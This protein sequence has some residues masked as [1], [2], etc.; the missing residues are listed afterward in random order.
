MN[1]PRNKLTLLVLLFSVGINLF[2]VG[3]IFYRVTL[4]PEFGPRP[5]PRNVSWIV[6]DLTEIRQQEL[7]PLL[8]RN[9]QESESLRR[10]MFIA[11]RQVNDLMARSNFDSDELNSAFTALRNASADY[12]KI[13]HQQTVDILSRLT[14][15][16]RKLAQEFLQRRGPRGGPDRGNFQPR[17]PGFNSNGEPRNPPEQNQ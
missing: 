10:D 2:L 11:Q 16:E 7:M 14:E 1:A 3:G 15:A 13:S 9:R 5:M 17:P 8:E 12:Q 6:R 4:H